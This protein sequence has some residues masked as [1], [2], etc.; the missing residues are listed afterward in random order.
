MEVPPGPLPTL[1]SRLFGS[2]RD[3]RLFRIIPWAELKWTLRTHQSI[4]Y[5]QAHTTAL[6]PKVPTLSPAQE[7]SSPEA[8][9]PLGRRIS[10]ARPS[11]TSGHCWLMTVEA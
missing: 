9:C 11:L 5:L 1:R 4:L 8:A 10:E 6:P 7:P 2:Q 3:G